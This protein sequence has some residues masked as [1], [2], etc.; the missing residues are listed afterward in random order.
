MDISNTKLIYLCI[1]CKVFKIFNDSGAEK[2]NGFRHFQDH[3]CENCNRIIIIIIKI[4]I[5]EIRA[6]EDLVIFLRS[7]VKFNGKLE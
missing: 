6:L 2:F 1:C 5:K 3:I 4:S 7:Y